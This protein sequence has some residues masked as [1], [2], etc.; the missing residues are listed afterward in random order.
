MALPFRAERLS[1]FL[2]MPG[3]DWAIALFGGVGT[4]F[5]LGLAVW[6]RNPEAFDSS[7]SKH[8]PL[9]LSGLWCGIS[10]WLGVR[11]WRRLWRSGRT[12]Q[13][14]M[15]YDR[16]VRGWGAVMLIAMPLLVGLVV[17]SV[18]DTYTDPNAWL[19]ILACVFM[20]FLAGLPV[21]L[22]G[23]YILGSFAASNR[24]PADHNEPKDLPP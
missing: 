7:Y 6:R 9:L 12:P 1:N 5:L 18:A 19:L 20:G 2:R 11:S 14:R 8:A 21:F 15:I 13:E 24:F 22:W 4:A 23:G 17:W 16:G 3:A 10:G